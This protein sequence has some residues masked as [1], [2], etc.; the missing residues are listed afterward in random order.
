MA[1]LEVAVHLESDGIR[2]SKYVA[3]TMLTVFDSELNDC[4]SAWLEFSKNFIYL[5]LFYI[6]LT[7][8]H[9]FLITMFDISPLK[10]SPIP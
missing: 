5:N 2:D 3:S 1:Q 8:I 10:F 7:S 4:E 9:F 6:K